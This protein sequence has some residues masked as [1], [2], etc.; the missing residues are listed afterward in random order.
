MALGGARRE[1]VARV[2]RQPDSGLLSLVS[3]PYTSV[4]ET[5]RRLAVLCAAF[6]ERADRRAVFLSV[7]VRMTEAVADRIDRGD[8][9]DPEWVGA[10]L[11]AFANLYREAVYHYENGDDERLAES[12]RLA[13]DA[14]ERGDSLVVQDAALGVNAHI[15]Y[16]LAVALERV[17]IDP[18]RSQKY[19]D[20]ER[21]TDVIRD[22][23]DGAQ[24]TLAA[25]DAPGVEALDRSLG[26]F[27]EWMVVFSIDECRD[28]AWRTAAA[29]QSRLPVRRRL[30]RWLNGVT[31]TGVAHVILA[32]HADAGV[33]E[34]LAALEASTPS[35]DET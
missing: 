5:H 24:D 20:H 13:F 15:N 28:S 33:H 3:D 9:D 10:Y 21:V 26:R 6:E 29:T 23:V 2:P 4:E 16:D 25:R 19:A 34:S 12:W 31:S 17:G 14:A 8:F 30:A 22:V 18:N 7:Y 27:D 11:V 35:R 32:S 1:R